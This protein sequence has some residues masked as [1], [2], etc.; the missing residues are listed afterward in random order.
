MACI[1]V[2]VHDITFAPGIEYLMTHQPMYFINTPANH[3]A[4]LEEL[5]DSTEA[6]IQPAKHQLVF[7][8]YV[9]LTLTCR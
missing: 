3:T 1:L 6:T 8:T 4:S 5:W 9:E 2:S 7:W